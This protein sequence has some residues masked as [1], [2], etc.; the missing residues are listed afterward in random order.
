MCAGVYVCGCVCV[1]VC[2]CAGVYVCGCV[3]AWPQ[4]L[5]CQLA[6]VCKTIGNDELE[7]KFTEASKMMKRDIVFAASLYL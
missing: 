2:M 7:Q 1:R 5:V 6:H 4:E 3:C